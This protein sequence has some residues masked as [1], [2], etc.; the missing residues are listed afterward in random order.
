MPVSPIER[1]LSPIETDVATMVFQEVAQALNG[2]GRRSLELRLPVPRAISGTEAKRRVLRDGAG[3]AHRLRHLDA[4]RQRHGH[5]DDAAAHPAGKHAASPTPRQRGT[6]GPTGGQRFS[7]RGDALDG[8][9]RGDHAAGPH[10]ARRLAGFEPGQV[11]EFE[12]TAQSQAKLSARATRRCSSASSANSGRTTP[13][14]SGIRSM[15]GRISSRA[16][17]GLSAGRA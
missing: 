7:R 17:A 4:G 1:D 16:D 3:G 10:D 12:E 8:D 13:S 5:G 11:I 15:P 2:S 6:T 9:A 14:G